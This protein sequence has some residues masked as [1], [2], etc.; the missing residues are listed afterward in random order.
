MYCVMCDVMLCGVS[1]VYCVMLCV[2]MLH[3]DVYVLCLLRVL[4]CVWML[5]FDVDV[6]RLLRCVLCDVL[7]V[8]VTFMCMCLCVVVCVDVTLYMCSVCGVVCCV[9]WC[10]V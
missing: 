3:Y 9:M 2:W 8:D 4:W 7:C 6:L 10:V 1:D 5:H